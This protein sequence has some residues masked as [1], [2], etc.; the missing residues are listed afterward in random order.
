MVE[1]PVLVRGAGSTGRVQGP[2]L[3]RRT[4]ED[5]VPALLEDLGDGD[6]LATVM[7]GRVTPAPG[8]P[9][10]VLHQPVHRVFHVVL[11]EVVCDSVGYPRLDPA[12]IESAGLV[13]RR[14]AV[15]ASGRVIPD[16]LESWMREA[17]T[18]R[19]R[20]EG[21]PRSRARKGW[22][23]FA[24]RLAESSA[25]PQRE[26]ARDLDRD[27][28]PAR[29]P[30]EIR[31]GRRELD[32]RLAEKGEPVA[33]EEAVT[34]LF[35]APPEVCRAAGKTLLYGLVPVT[36]TE[37]GDAPE[38]LPPFDAKTLSDHLPQLFKAGAPPLL[39][40]AGRVLRYADVR[41]K[42]PPAE[43]TKFVQQL[44]QIVTELD[45]FGPGDAPE[46]LRKELA[47]L[48]LPFL[49][50]KRWP[51]SRIQEGLDHVQKVQGD[52]RR[53]GRAD[54]PQG[55]VKRTAAEFLEE[56]SRALL[57]PDDEGAQ[58]RMPL[59]WAT[60]AAEQAARLREA[61]RGALT[62]RLEAA[63]P[64]EG[65]YDDPRRQYRARAFVRVREEGSDC[66]PRLVWS[67]H[68][69]PFT[70]APWFASG[71]APPVTVPLPDPT[72][73]AALKALKPNVSFAVPKGL[74]DFMQANDAKKLIDGDGEKGGPGLAL[75]WICSFSIPIITLC[76]FIVL[77]IFL[78]LFDLIFRWLLF[79]KICL[80]IPRRQ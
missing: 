76:A 69:E 17:P 75:D 1:H 30:P 2:L 40:N 79:I 11:L 27:P 61:S 41:K 6:G 38:P 7:R 29:R 23:P 9:R 10:L 54:V 18:P 46:A 56:A 14:Q 15:D 39:P 51:D 59:H 34:P 35:V 60:I 73:R 8:A 53:L 48:E 12:S 31:T 50:E 64:K 22:V 26:L 49:D 4:E 66:P 80:P 13:V 58:V 65:R 32:R 5:F 37:Q 33:L 25:G 71:G 47:L 67:D 72:D 62:A 24:D 3:L 42:S 52:N 78:H 63:R 45:A 20:S 77:N 43:V 74:M 28:D 44:R 70:I 19:S 21:A 16:A 68:S 36:S 57:A 55:L